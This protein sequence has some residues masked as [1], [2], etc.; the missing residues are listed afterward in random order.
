M[1]LVWREH[2]KVV[3]AHGVVLVLVAASLVR[4]P[5]ELLPKWGIGQRPETGFCQNRQRFWWISMIGIHRGRAT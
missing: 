1:L 3:S 2:G 4:G 5:R